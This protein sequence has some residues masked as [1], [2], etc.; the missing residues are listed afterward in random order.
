MKRLVL[1]VLIMSFCFSTVSFALDTVLS[2]G[3][4]SSSIAG[5][6]TFDQPISDRTNVRLG[7][8]LSAGS[9]QTV[10]LFGI[11]T[12]IGKYLEKYPVSLFLGMVTEPNFLVSGYG[13]GLVFYDV[14]PNNNVLTECGVDVSTNTGTSL[15]AV[16][17]YIQ[18]GYRL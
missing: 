3:Y 5:V 11:N 15:S 16:R 10:V 13:V 7:G 4:R 6:L 14:F 12:N 17:P 2:A 1:A 9:P 8:V 18:I